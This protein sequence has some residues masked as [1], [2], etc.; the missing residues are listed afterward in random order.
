MYASDFFHL[1][2]TSDVLITYLKSEIG[3]FTPLPPCGL[4]YMISCMLDKLK[5]SLLSDQKPSVLDSLSVYDEPDVLLDWKI[6]VEMF[7]LLASKSPNIIS[8][9]ASNPPSENS[10]KHLDDAMF[11]LVAQV[12]RELVLYNKPIQA[13]LQLILSTHAKQ[14]NPAVK[15]RMK[16]TLKL[17]GLPEYLLNEHQ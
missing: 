5:E 6:D 9:A 14:H 1:R 4:T 8:S 10:D 7:K 12:L 11:F 13:R 2:S 15:E 3:I 17:F 16:T